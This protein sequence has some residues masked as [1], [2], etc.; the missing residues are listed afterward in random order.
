[1][2]RL[3]KAVKHA[4]E[5][6]QLVKEANITDARSQLEVTVGI[7]DVLLLFTIILLYLGVY[8]MDASHLGV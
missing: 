3:R 1:M 8:F 6:A 5:F 4:S 2:Q 7:I